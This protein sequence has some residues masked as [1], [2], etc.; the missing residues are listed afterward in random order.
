MDQR[1]P[2]PLQQQQE[3][4]FRVLTAVQMISTEFKGAVSETAKILAI[5]E[6]LL[7]LTKQIGQWSS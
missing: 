1:V 5:T 3:E 2:A 4:Q 7:N 6:T